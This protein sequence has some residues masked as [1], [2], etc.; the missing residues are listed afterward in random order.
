M[1]EAGKEFTF[2]TSTTESIKKWINSR[3]H[4]K[5]KDLQNTISQAQSAQEIIYFSNKRN[6]IGD[7]NMWPMKVGELKKKQTRKR[8]RNWHCHGSFWRGLQFETEIKGEKG[9]LMIVFKKTS[10]DASKSY[11]CLIHG[12]KR[13]IDSR[14]KGMDADAREDAAEDSHQVLEFKMYLKIASP[15]SI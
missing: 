15:R 9:K 2:G 13:D 4:I 3:N 11:Q 7:H 5:K 10:K 8:I 6:R 1:S 12:C 14:K